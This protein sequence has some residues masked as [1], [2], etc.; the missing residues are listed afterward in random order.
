MKRIL[1]CVL[2]FMLAALPVCALAGC[3]CVQP[4]EYQIGFDEATC[5]EPG[6]FV[7]KC[8]DCG[9]T[10]RE[11]AKDKLGHDYQ[12]VMTNPAFCES[13]GKEWY[14]CT[15]CGDTQYQT[16]P[17]LG[18]NWEQVG[19]KV[20]TCGEK[21]AYY[22]QCSNCNEERTEERAATGNH[23]WE[24]TH[25]NRDDVECVAGGT[26]YYICS[27]CGDQKNESVPATG[28]KWKAVSA[29]GAT[30]D[31]PKTV[32]YQC[33]VCNEKK[34][35]KEGSP[36]EHNWQQTYSEPAT[37]AADG[38]KSYKCASCS[39][40]KMVTIPATG[41][42]TYG[43]WIVAVNASCDKDGLKVAACTQC[44]D[45]KEQKIPAAGHKW[46]DG[47]IIKQPTCTEDGKASSVCERCGATDNARTLKKLGHSYG[48]AKVTKEATCT[49]EGESKQTCKVCGAVKTGKV[50][51][52]GHS[53]GDWKVTKEAT[54]SAEGT[55]ERTCKTCGAKETKAIPKKG[56]V[57]PKPTNTPKP[58]KT[59]GVSKIP[60]KDKDK[61]SGSKKSSGSNYHYDAADG[62][63]E[64]YTTSGKVNLRSGPG[65][66]NGLA[67]QVPKK[68]TCLGNLIEAQVDSTGTVWYKVRY[69]NKNSWIT[70]DYADVVIGDMTY[71]D[72]R[73][74]G[75]D[76]VDLSDICFSY[77]SEAADHYGLELDMSGEAS[78]DALTIGG[79]SEFVEYIELTG[80]G[81]ALYGVEIGDKIKTVENAMKRNGLYCASKGGSVYTYKRPC[82]PY[83]MCVTD[84]GF[85]SYIEVVLDSSKCVESISWNAYT[86]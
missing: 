22:L 70:S 69:K 50:K 79:T 33:S 12:Y 47:Q 45:K 53:Y 42:C 66:K 86:E 44:G 63:I 57:T 77:V 51:A 6:Y 52:T 25:T 59:S 34:T 9:G 48:T 28:H 71:S 18:H 36:A 37:C 29:L 4:N 40:D 5:T 21:G 11:K 76:S 13:N 10:W 15:R 20:P 16:I 1:T 83:S 75:I 23:K 8:A 7:L 41:K 19:V 78:D 26:A 43:E 85:D 60:A 61:A 49:T 81:Y 64:I 73:H 65:K 27:V 80:E 82:Q 2:L 17:K 58:E 67:N 55:Q 72:D 46:K 56:T 3:Q 68:N 31:S 84:D 35:E 74:V 32:T 30:C 38:Y 39:K 62:E 54:T 24:Y 14:E